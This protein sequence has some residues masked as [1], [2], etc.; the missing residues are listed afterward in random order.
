MTIEEIFQCIPTTS[1]PH[2]HVVPQDLEEWEHGSVVKMI[3]LKGMKCINYDPEVMGSKPGRVE[4]GVCSPSEL[5][6]EPK[7]LQMQ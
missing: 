2:H 6:F 5:G 3:H 4:L 1:Y 7:I